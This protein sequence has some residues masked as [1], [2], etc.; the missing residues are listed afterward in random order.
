MIEGNIEGK[1]SRGRTPMRWMDRIETVTGYRL[2]EDGAVQVGRKSQA[3]ESDCCRYRL[4]GSPE[5]RVWNMRTREEVDTDGVF[6]QHRVGTIFVFASI[7]RVHICVQPRLVSTR[8][9][10]YR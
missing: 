1:R 7:R 10:R 4:E 3:L 9:G 8:S 6:Q 5:F 2:Q